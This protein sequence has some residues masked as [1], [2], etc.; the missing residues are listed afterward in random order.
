MLVG[1]SR[2]TA[3][4]ASIFDRDVVRDSVEARRLIGVSPQEY[5]FDENLKTKEILTYHAGYY[6]MPREER[7]QRADEIL[8]FLDIKDKSDVY[9]DKL[10]GG[11]K[12]RLLIGRALIQRPKVLFLD[13]PTTGV[14]VQLRRALWKMLK[15]LNEDGTTIVLTTHYIEE[16]ESL[17]D[18]VAIM[19]HGRIIALG[20]PEKLKKTEVDSSKLE[21]D[22]EGDSV[23]DLKAIPEVVRYSYGKNKLTVHV[24]DTGT[25]AVKLLDYLRTGHIAVKSMHVRESTLE[26]VFLKLTGRDLRE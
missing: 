2:P 24:T 25:A 20:S 14:D 8:E 4:S 26:D 15:K 12:R 22:I 6:G 16:A 11:M 10:S 13:E 7:E 23:P 19:D 18:R 9:S 5:N 17:C 3:G 1:L 21:F